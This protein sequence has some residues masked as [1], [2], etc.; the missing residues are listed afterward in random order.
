MPSA[1]T[2]ERIQD[3][4]TRKTDGKGVTTGL[5]RVRISFTSYSIQFG[6][7]FRRQPQRRRLN[8]LAQMM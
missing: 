1:D 2:F 7:R 6:H 5:L 3:Y 4:L 8:V